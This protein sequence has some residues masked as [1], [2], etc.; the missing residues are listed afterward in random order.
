MKKKNIPPLPKKEEKKNVRRIAEI[1]LAVLIL[2]WTVCS[3][4]G[5]IGFARSCDEDN[6]A[7]LTASADEVSTY[8]IDE[9]ISYRD[10]LIEVP[11]HYTGFVEYSNSTNE[12]L[13]LP[14]FG[15][16]IINP[17]SAAVVGYTAPFSGTVNSMVRDGDNVR[18]N[19]FVQIQDSM[20]AVVG[21][22]DF[23]T[24]FKPFNSVLNTSM[25]TSVDVLV[26]NNGEYF[27]DS[28]NG[29]FGFRLRLNY[30]DNSRI[31]LLIYFTVKN[32]QHLAISYGPNY[33]YSL[34]GITNYT[35]DYYLNYG[36]DDGYDVG[37]LEGSNNAN[38][39]LYNEGYTTGQNVGYNQGYTAGV[40]DSNEYTFNGLITSIIDVPI[41]AITGLFNFEILGV[42]LSGFF[43]A[44]LTVCVVLTVAKL[45][46]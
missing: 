25:L 20:G 39:E 16:L 10:R 18:G 17:S 1:V 7:V 41:K 31:N 38:Q 24:E 14:Y 21:F 3:V 30:E 33:G 44:L 45:F 15:S 34:L 40:A 36:F 35:Q 6:F 26:V 46:I 9:S 12:Y 4:L 8:A 19:Y 37:L 32:S 22:L 43:F 23:Y 28:T 11:L 13:G 42:N 2:F 29:L 27:P 5:V